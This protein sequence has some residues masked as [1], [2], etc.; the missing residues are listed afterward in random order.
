MRI[1]K[2]QAVC[3][4]QREMGELDAQGRRC[5][6]QMD[7]LAG[8]RLAD[9][10]GASISAAEQRIRMQ[11]ATARALL[12][13]CQSLKAADGQN[14]SLVQGLPETSSGVLD[15]VVAQ[16]RIERAKSQI[17]QLDW[18]RRRAIAQAKEANRSAEATGGPYVDIGGINRRYELL[19][20]SQQIV[21]K[22]NQRILEQA[23]QYDR[24]SQGVYRAVDTSYVSQAQ[25]SIGSYLTQG[26]WGSTA[27]VGKLALDKAVDAYLGEQA[28]PAGPDTLQQFLEGDLSL[29]DSAISAKMTQEGG[30]KTLVTSGE[31]VGLSLAIKPYSNKTQKLEDDKPSNPSVGIKATGE[32]CLAKGSAKE[33]MAFGSASISGSVLTGAVSGQVGGSLGGSGGDAPILTAKV[34]S[35]ASVLSGDVGV[36]VGVK[37]YNGHLK[38]H[39]EALTAGAEAGI[40]LDENGVKAKVGAEAYLAKG[41]ISG[42]L[43]LLG[44][45]I[46][47][48][49]EAKAGGAGAKAGGG[50]GLTS[51]EGEL[52]LGF[53]VGLSAK[54]KVDWSGALKALR[55][56]RGTIE[57]WW[58]ELHEGEDEEDV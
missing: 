15:T 47:A 32:V 19:I 46:D 34:S 17:Q 53:G 42:G 57:S 37:D 56:L 49:L 10:S 39:A 55:N 16:E 36:Q 27:W 14:A 1:V 25:E 6:R 12:A 7:K 24:A 4:L 48:S 35:S 29:S 5:Q 31:V 44:V 26:T 33:S 50:V 23:Q 2:D 22:L 40:T 58:N 18:H 21:V 8:F 30:G 28:A 45:K 20:Q 9:M 52:G 41:E 54:V 11:S 13:F 38:A 43:T 3:A 51:V